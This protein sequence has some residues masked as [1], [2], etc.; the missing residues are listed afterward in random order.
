M[1]GAIAVFVKTPGVSPVK[2]RLAVNLGKQNAEAFHIASSRAVESIVQS[3][4]EQENIESYYAVA[5][6]STLNH[7]YWQNL[8]SIWQGEGGLGERMAHIY[9]SLLS[10][11]D[12][13]ILVGADSPQMTVKQLQQAT[14]WLPHNEQARLA[15]APSVDGGFWLFG[16][17]C[18]IPRSVWTDVTYSQSDTGEQFANKIKKLGDL[19]LLE[20]L[21]DVDEV[22]DLI[23]L[24]NDLNTLHS[25]TVAQQELN[26]FLDEVLV[27]VLTTS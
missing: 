6:P 21:R 9:Q 26:H 23:H 4:S 19:K 8:S 13:V 11:H 20:T 18:H 12:Y 17:N 14:D 27:N 2:T 24:Q 3:L 15:F 5:E 25:P 7:I 16:G 22:D 1:S 10:Q